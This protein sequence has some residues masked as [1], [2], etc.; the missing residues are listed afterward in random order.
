MVVICMTQCTH[1][2]VAVDTACKI[3]TVQSSGYNTNYIVILISVLCPDGSIY[4]CKNMDI[5]EIIFAYEC[6]IYW[7]NCTVMESPMVWC[8][9]SDCRM[10]TQCVSICFVTSPRMHDGSILY[11]FCSRITRWSFCKFCM[12]KDYQQSVILPLLQAWIMCSVYC[13][14]PY[15]SVYNIIFLFLAMCLHWG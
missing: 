7:Y 2:V 15:C 12:L 4:I 13:G 5:L 6:Y 9:F 3:P 8:C 11:K 10:E 14:L 1:L